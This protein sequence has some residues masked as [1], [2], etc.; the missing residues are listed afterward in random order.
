[1]LNEQDPLHFAQDARKFQ[2][3][4]RR[5]AKKHK[6]YVIQSLR[7]YNSQE[8]D[9]PVKN[10]KHDKPEI[11]VI[12]PAPPPNGLKR[13]S[14]NETG[15]DGDDTL[16][17]LQSPKAKKSVRFSE[18]VQHFNYQESFA[19]RFHFNNVD[20]IIATGDEWHSQ[21][22]S[23]STIPILTSF[24]KI[25]EETL[26]SISDTLHIDGGSNQRFMDDEDFYEVHSPVKFPQRASFLYHDDVSMDSYGTIT[27]QELLDAFQKAS[28]E[29]T[30][31]SLSDLDRTP[32]A[33]FDDSY[34][35][36]DL[37]YVSEP[38]KI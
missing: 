17:S 30:V 34:L 12:V 11:P 21:H 6:P 22:S 25:L 29:L 18:R 35:Y 23:S 38:S 15:H 10:K 20:D 24:Q 32:P 33:C 13:I 26:T 16:S 4:L 1:M 14:P 2:R 37:V 3:Q 28:E 8:K 36:T 7:N 31:A 9:T 19:S 5:F 27:S